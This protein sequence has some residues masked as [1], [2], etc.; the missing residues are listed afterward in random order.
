MFVQACP[1]PE[2]IM[3][4]SL[5]FSEVAT[6]LEGVFET[7]ARGVP[8]QAM[9]CMP[10]IPLMSTH[11]NLSVSRHF[12]VTFLPGSVFTAL[13]MSVLPRAEGGDP[14]SGAFPYFLAS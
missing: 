13:T 12:S 7:N 6:V 4:N 3:D 1:T 8:I 10:S 9:A 2:T 5:L 11:V 14:A